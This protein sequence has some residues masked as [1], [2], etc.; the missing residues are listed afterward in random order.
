MK[1]W[2]GKQAEREREREEKRQARL[3]RR[4]AM[5]NHKFE[6]PVYDQQRQLLAENQEDAIQKGISGLIVHVYR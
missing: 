5:P 4:R 2:L 3:A 1:D 6:D